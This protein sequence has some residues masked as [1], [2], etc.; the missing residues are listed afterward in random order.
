MRVFFY[1]RGRVREV[2]RWNWLLRFLGFTTRDKK[3]VLKKIE[4]SGAE[5][6]KYCD[7]YSK[8][9]EVEISEKLSD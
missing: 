5:L 6:R 2:K 8:L 3:S 4:K 9:C 1:V 7:I